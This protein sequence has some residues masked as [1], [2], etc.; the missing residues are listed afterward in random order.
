MSAENRAE[1]KIEVEDFFAGV[2]ARPTPQTPNSRPQASSPKL[3]APSL[4]SIPP[5]PM[6][7]A[8]DSQPEPRTPSPDSQAPYP[9]SET[10]NPEPQAPSSKP[11]LPNCNSGAVRRDAWPRERDGRLARPLHAQL[12]AYVY[13]DK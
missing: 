11:Q 9:K 12:Y 6:P 5:T 2:R 7:Q 1:N 8:P 10:R 13:V 4:N 3:Q